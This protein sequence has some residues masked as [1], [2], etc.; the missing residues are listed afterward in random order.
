MVKY[1]IHNHPK[2]LIRRL[3]KEKTLIHGSLYSL[4][5]FFGRGVTF[6]LLIILAKYIQPVEYG[7]LSLFSTVVTFLTYFMAFSCNGYIGISYFKNE[8]QDFSKDFSII[9]QLGLF[10]LLCYI[11][12]VLVGGA[13]LAEKLELTIPLLWVAIFIPF[14]DMLYHAYQNFY[15]IKEKIVPYGIISCSYA[16]LNFSLSILLVVTFRQGWIGRIETQIACSLLF[17]SLGV[18]YFL[19]HHYVVM[20]FSWE[21][22]KRILMWGIP[23]IPHMGA[24]WIR[25]GLDQYIINYNYSVYEVGLFS[26]ALNVAGVII[27]IG[28]AFND[29]NSVTI[30]KT[31]S[32]KNLTNAQKQQSLNKQTKNIYIIIIAATFF[33]LLFIPSIIYWGMPKYIPAIPYFLI[34]S[35]YG[36]I[37]CVYFLYC[38][39]LFYY[40]KTNNLMKITF[41]TSIVHLVLSLLLTPYSLYFTGIIYIL[42][43]SLLVG[44]VYWQSQ[45]LIKNHLKI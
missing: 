11:L 39:Y 13:W 27:M 38:N 7:L 44:L 8:R 5:S 15:R 16:I 35:V 12:I 17:A 41:G 6:V 10:S 9:L 20:S 31:L 3:A 18:V 32:D 23:M 26:F 22:T 45:K 37:Q 34:L 33:L 42:I 4:F 2:E 30:Y 43:Q 1:F 40:G 21:R 25:R 29:S 14:V 19:R 28:S 36:F 24:I